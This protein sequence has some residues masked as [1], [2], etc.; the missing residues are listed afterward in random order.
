ME[1]GDRMAIQ[2]APVRARFLTLLDDRL[3]MIEYHRASLGRTEDDR[4]SMLGVRDIVHKISGTAGTLGFADMGS[5]A[6][7]VEL[8]I[9]DEMQAEG[10]VKAS[11]G[12]CAQI[13]DFLETAAQV[14]I[15]A[16]EQSTS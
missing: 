14:A 9:M 13:D 6:A 11:A 4:A 10:T 8:A 15:A 2:L 12:L 5:Q 16:E 3:D 1:P 7:K